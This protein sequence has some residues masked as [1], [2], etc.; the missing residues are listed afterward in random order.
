VAGVHPEW[1]CVDRVIA[2]EGAGEAAEYLVKWRL[3]PYAEATWEAAADLA[4]PEDQVCSK[5]ILGRWSVCPWCATWPR[6]RT[7]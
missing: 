4:S 1:R 7:R 3:L 2:R 6:L 5:F